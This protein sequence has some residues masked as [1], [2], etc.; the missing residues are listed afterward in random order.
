MAKDITNIAILGAGLIGAAWAAF[1]NSK[2]LSVK[3]Y[4]DDRAALENGRE[5]ATDHLGF[6]RKHK[7]IS[8]DGYERAV[9]ELNLAHSIPEAVSNAELVMESAT[10]RYEVKKR[11]F[12]EADQHASCDCI[13]ASSSSALLMSEIQ[14]VMK[15]PGRSLI[16]HPFNPAHLVPLVELVAG[17]HT[18]QKVICRT[19]DFFERLGKTVVIV[20]KEIPGY[21]ANRLQAAVWREAIDMVIRGVG[22]VEDIDRALYAGPGIRWALMGQHLIFHLGGGK[23]G[24]EHFIEHIGEKKRQL[25]EDMASWTTIPDKAKKVLSKGIEQETRGKTIPEIEQWR[26]EKL[27]S[28]LQV[29]Y[30]KNGAATEGRSS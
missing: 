23:G 17:K 22:T 6:L 27:I 7:I 8:K 18:D 10:E 30:G 9:C 13:I 14:K 21:I 25:W 11:I 20:K 16:A 26:D 2:G 3:L 1:F 24:I 4:D 5:T 28:L 29:I 12:Q 19:K 15:Y